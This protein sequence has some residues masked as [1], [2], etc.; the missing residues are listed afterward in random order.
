MRALASSSTIRMRGRVAMRSRADSAGTSWEA[1]AVRETAAS[2]GMLLGPST[3]RASRRRGPRSRRQ[4]DREH[5]PARSAVELD[6]SAVVGDDAV[7]D[8]QPEAGAALLGGEERLEDRIV[9]R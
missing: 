6:G 3:G 1:Q 9:G 5:R 2:L 8:G 7:R 4:E